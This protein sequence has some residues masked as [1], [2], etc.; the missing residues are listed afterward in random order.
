M[1]ARCPNARPLSSTRTW[2]SA[3]F[4]A[5]MLAGGARLASAQ[6]LD[7]NLWV[8]DGDVHTVVPSGNTLYV[9]GTFAYVGP[10]SGGWNEVD[11]YGRAV[12]HLPRVDGDILGT[13]SDGA[14]G[15]WICG[16][17]TRIAGLARP[18]IAHV[19]AD[20]SV[21][22]WTPV[23]A[24]HAN[25]VSIAVQG[26]RVFAVTS[27]SVFYAYD[28]QTGDQIPSWNPAVLGPVSSMVVD[29]N[30]L[31]CA[32]DFTF[33]ITSPPG[34]GSG[35]CAIDTN[36][37]AIANW[38]PAP[39]GSV[40]KL[41]TDG[42]WLYATGTFTEIGGQTHEGLA[43]A[44]LTAG[45]AWDAA[46]APSIDSPLKAL[47]RVG[48][49]LWIS[50][51]F[52][53]VNGNFVDR[54]TVVDTT[55][56]AIASPTPI[57]TGVEGQV[58]AMAVRSPWIY[59]GI[60]PTF[61]FPRVQSSRPLL[62]RMN[63]S[64][65]Q[66]DGTWRS[67]GLSSPTSVDVGSVTD[68]K[69]TSSGG[70]VASGHF[71]SLGGRRQLAVAA[72]DRATGIP[73]MWDPNLSVTEAFPVVPSVSAI[74]PTPN[75]VYLG[76]YF[77]RA[78]GQVR[79]S[80]AAVDPAYA[81]LRPWKA[82]LGAVVSLESGE[83]KALLLHQDKIL[84][85]GAFSSIAGAPRTSLA[86]VDSVVG[87]PV[88]GW[89][90][91]VDDQV[92]CLLPRGGM[93]YVGGGFTSVDGQPHN[94]LAA[95]NP[96]TGDVSSWD[97][98]VQGVQVWSL[99]AQNDTLYIAGDY[100]HVGGQSRVCLAAVTLS[101]G[102]LLGW[103]PS[104]FGPAIAILIQGPNLLVG[105]EF[106]FLAGQMV[107]FLGRVDR[108]TAALVTGSPTVDDRVLA[109]APAEGGGT[110]IAGSFGKFTGAPA[111]FLAH[112]GWPGNTPPAVTVVRANG[113]EYLSIGTTYHFQYTASDPSGVASVDLELSRTGN[114]GPWTTLAAGLPNKGVL[115]W[116]VT[117]PDASNTA[118]LRVTARGFSGTTT[119][120]LSNLAFSI[121]APTASV[122]GSDR[123]LA[124]ALGPNPARAETGLHFSLRE[125]SRI[126][127]RL[128]DVQG[129]AMWSSPE[130]SFAAGE[131]QVRC[132]LEGI[133]PG[134]YFVRV[135]RGRESTS[136]RLVVVH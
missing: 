75:A 43:R 54:L 106:Q 64:D 31:Y 76:G 57:L 2:M 24:P 49:E 15:W 1:A 60:T 136:A 103:A 39:A 71:V 104:A 132:P 131:H 90:C 123:A 93:V 25:P 124:F 11:G 133:A 53:F 85:G 94:D 16:N 35:L 79:K 33:T 115:D 19:L 91:D 105:G 6:A 125:P 13:V 22:P 69:L 128:I 23:P 89:A 95:I 112:T 42:R 58:T 102:A 110:Y 107:D 27:V 92:N 97:P 72:L 121:G 14:G 56:G 52:F 118:F 96:T 28:A 45:H 108:F 34:N 8:T 30:T 78:A 10:N 134:L 100:S 77:T 44:L 82:D 4:L 5:A 12:A 87:N 67:Y 122:V 117:G 61:T 83:A 88:P 116:V 20:G 41:F 99:A 59:L 127:F 111:A 129:R 98:N 36:T 65:G 114:T 119:T 81:I 86:L 29:G 66:V 38:D 126:R 113:G 73:R 109:L 3:S 47:A 68:L 37:G 63:P 55:T 74:L 135:E 62:V 9:G 48:E 7:A 50:G 84:V 17:F 101:T 32:G 70:L 51:Q 40:T 21:S 120:D 130:R 80:L 18:G 26:S 46:W